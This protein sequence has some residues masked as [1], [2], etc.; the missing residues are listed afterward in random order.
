LCLRCS[1]AASFLH[2][3]LLSLLNSLLVLGVRHEEGAEVDASA[4]A[5]ELG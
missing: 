3:L 4:V 1:S 2:T 5:D